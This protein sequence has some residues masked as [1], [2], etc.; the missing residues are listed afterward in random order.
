MD[1]LHYEKFPDGTVKCIQDEIPFE[2]SEGWE[3]VR[4]GNI[5]ASIQYGLGN[6]SE[7]QGTH[8][9]LRIT[10][11]QDGKVNWDNVPFTTIE[12]AETYLLKR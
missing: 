10:D 11:I 7:A 2:L 3:W 5:S 6:S 9:L 8:R 1:S 4:L 12:N